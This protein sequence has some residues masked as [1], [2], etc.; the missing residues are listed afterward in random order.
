[1][2]TVITNT[3]KA[4]ITGRFLS[5]SPLELY[6]GWGEGT[7]AAAP[8]DIALSSEAPEGRERANVAQVT[9]ATQQDTI[10]A[11]ATLMATGQRA[12]TNAAIFDAATN[13]NMIFKG[14]FLPVNLNTGDSITF[15]LKI[16]LL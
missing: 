14:D 15:S 4:L 1:M 7:G 6:I 9:T 13:G 5:D 3:G 10:E 12:I 11:T 2:A 8:D 16:Q